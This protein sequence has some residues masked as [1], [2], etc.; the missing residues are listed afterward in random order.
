MQK[1]TLQTIAG[2]TVFAFAMG[3]LEGAVVIYLRE[4]YFPCGFRFPVQVFAPHIART[5]LLRELSTLVM[6]LSIGMLLGRTRYEKIAYFIYCFGVWDLVYYLFL[7]HLIGWP[8]SLLTWDILF[9]IPTIWV[10]PVVAPCINSVTMIA[11]GFAIICFVDNNKASSFGPVVWSL[12]IAG[13]LAIMVSYLQDF[14]QYMAHR[15]GYTCC[16]KVFGISETMKMVSD[17]VPSHFNWALF[18]AGVGLHWTAA[19]VYFR[20][21]LLDAGK[22]QG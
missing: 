1:R 17:Y 18:L 10:G 3:F 15:E 9:L 6:L 7:K 21:I 2:V 13:T 20:N 22:K 11:V 14:V 19:G 16:A 8:D 5:E 12:F 4:I